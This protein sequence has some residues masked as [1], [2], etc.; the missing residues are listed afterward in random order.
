MKKLFTILLLFLAVFIFYSFDG[1]QVTAAPINNYLVLEG[2]Y[3]KANPPTTSSPAAFSF[4]AW[5]Y[6]YST[7]GMQK[8]LSI[9]DKNSGQLDYE[10]G[11][12]GGSLSLDYLYDTNSERLITAG[13]IIPNVWT[14][15]AV[16]IDQ[17]NTKLFLNGKVIVITSGTNKL[18][19]ISPDVIM[20]GSF[21]Q[22]QINAYPFKGYLDEVRISTGKRD[23]EKLWAE[24]KYES[25][26]TND[27]DTY[28][29]WHL[30]GIRGEIE[31]FD[32]SQN[33][34]NAQL[35]GGDS[36]IHFFGVLPSPTPFILRWN[37]PVLPTLRLPATIPTSTPIITSPPITNPIPPIDYRIF[38][39]EQ[40]GFRI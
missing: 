1:F 4:E 30:D 18:K 22:N 14:H 13:N 21:T 34:L 12:N 10:I 33:G 19:P 20:G 11:I 36:K 8:I 17:N 28:S 24:G 32:S 26:S 3:L 40:R 31:A 38:P 9:G 7:T 25:P 16:L 6:P 23:V 27:G 5:I 15:I 2:G 39:R 35:I 37:R 29:L